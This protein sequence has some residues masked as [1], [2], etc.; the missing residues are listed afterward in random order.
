[1][2]SAPAATVA[3]A[4]AP[5]SNPPPASEPATKK[6]KKLVLNSL[7]PAT[8]TE[9]QTAQRDEMLAL[10]RSLGFVCQPR[11]GL[12]MDLGQQIFSRMTNRLGK[13]VSQCIDFTMS[14]PQEAA[15]L[16]FST[17]LQQEEEKTGTM[18]WVSENLADA[19][20]LMGNLLSLVSPSASGLT[21]AICPPSESVIRTWSTLMPTIEIKSVVQNHG[22]ER[23]Y[24]RGTY[25]LWD[26]AAEIH[27]PKDAERRE[28][29][30]SPQLQDQLRV[31]VLQ[32]VLQLSGNCNLSANW[33][34]QIGSEDIAAEV[35]A[36]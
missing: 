16:I 33:W 34:R 35:E 7:A 13:A 8:L 14:F 18:R 25:V 31:R 26:D 15:M 32:D 9:E 19:A 29:A 22:A 17:R 21:R 11:Q 12:E 23:L 30:L 4:P 6:V 2:A 28:M 10:A 27:P 3:P 20:E 1:M 24:F 36:G 5:A